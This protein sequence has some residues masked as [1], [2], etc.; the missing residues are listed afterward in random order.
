[1]SKKHKKNKNCNSANNNQTEKDY[2][3]DE[4]PSVHQRGKLKINL[5]IRKRTDLTDNQKKFLEL[6][7]DKNTKMMFVSGPAGT[8]KTFLAVM[9]VLQ[10]LDDKKVS[11]LIYLRS[12]VESSENKMGYLPGTEAEK[13]SPYLQPLVDKLNE[14]LPKNEVD[15][16]LKEQRIQGQPIN[17]LRGINWNAKVI[18]LDEGQNATAKELTTL[19]TRAGEFSKLFILSDP[20]QNDL[21]GKSGLVKMMEIFNDEESIQNGILTFKFTEEDIVRSVLV[22]F[23]V[24]KLRKSNLKT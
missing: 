4:S 21:N 24:Q 22:K 13:L 2:L 14:L 17:Y 6:A 3:K 5:N 11:D 8:S 12:I 20:E 10:L 9:S 16:L 7:L 1:M 23:I 19:I 18:I 15:F